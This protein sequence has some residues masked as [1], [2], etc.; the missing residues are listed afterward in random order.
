VPLWNRHALVGTSSRLRDLAL[1]AQGN[2]S[3]YDAW[4]AEA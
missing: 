1:D 2:L 4:L 3:L